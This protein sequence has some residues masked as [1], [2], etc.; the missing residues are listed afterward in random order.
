MALNANEIGTNSSESEL[1]NLIKL[2]TGCDYC[3]ITAVNPI[4][5]ISCCAI[6]NATCPYLLISKIQIVI[7]KTISIFIQVKLK[8][9]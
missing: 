9:K 7:L 5:D 1:Q 4:E 6:S 8:Q 3:I 2:L